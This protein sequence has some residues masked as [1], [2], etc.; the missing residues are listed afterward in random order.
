VAEWLKVAKT[1]EIAPGEAKAV[2]VGAQ[3]IA[4]F[5]IEGTYHAID[6][7]C[8]HRGGPLSEGVVEGTEVTCP[9]HG[10]VFDVTTGSVL[11]AP[12]PRDVAHYAARVE[13]NDIEIE[14]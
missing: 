8:T 3:R 14:L 9:W 5:N 10:A 2:A 1:G 6:D 4:L 11:G 12:A 7:A 13:S